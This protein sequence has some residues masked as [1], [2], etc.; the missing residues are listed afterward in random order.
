MNAL[1]QRIE[2]T[3]TAKTARLWNCS[4]RTVT[5]K[6][7]DQGSIRLD[8]IRQYSRIKLFS[9]AECFEIVNGRRPTLKELEGRV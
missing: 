8:E 5:R 9:P 1:I 7:E 4:E 2:E 3:G 6:R